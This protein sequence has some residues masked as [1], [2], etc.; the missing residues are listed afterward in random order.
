MAPPLEA[1]I[2]GMLA[3]EISHL[4]PAGLPTTLRRVID[5]LLLDDIGLCVAARQTDYVRTALAAAD[6]DGSCTVIGQMRPLSATGA[7]LIK[8]I[9]AHGEDFDDTFEG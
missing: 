8:G 1:S 5:D 6:G 4:S 2:A 3:R 7:A 9:A